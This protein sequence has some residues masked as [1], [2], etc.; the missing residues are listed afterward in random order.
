[1]LTFTAGQWGWGIFVYLK[2]LQSQTLLTLVQTNISDEPQIKVLCALNL[3]G[4]TIFF[5]IVMV[6]GTFLERKYK[7][8]IQYNFGLFTI[9]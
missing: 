7:F 4:P 2:C 5:K 6:I 1:M 8:F 3:W 9:I